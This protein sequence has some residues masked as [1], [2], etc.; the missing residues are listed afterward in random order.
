M[1]NEWGHNN[2]KVQELLQ[3]IRLI[4]QKLFLEISL[5]NSDLIVTVR[6]IKPFKNLRMTS[7]V[8]NDKMKLFAFLI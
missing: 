2:Y 3:R 5:Q 6:W 8:K 1:K 7:L 4:M